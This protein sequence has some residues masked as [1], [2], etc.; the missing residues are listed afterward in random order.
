MLLPVLIPVLLGFTGSAGL[1]ASRVSA[2]AHV[3]NGLFDG[4]K[5]AFKPLAPQDE[6]R[7]T[8]IDRWLGIDKD[9]R[10]QTPVRTFVEPSDA[11]N[12][13]IIALAKPMG[14]K[15]VENEDGKGIVVQALVDSGSAATTAADIKPGDQLVSVDGT[16]VLGLD[17][18]TALG[19]IM[20]SADSTVKMTV[21]RGP[22]QFLYGPT[23]P[24]DEWLRANVSA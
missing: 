7:I 3:A 10:K 23:R 8:P 2:R 5:D 21:F 12:Y 9:V 22:A 17:F 6:D 14:I 19:A 11:A 1:R 16:L 15:F 13:R 18:D 24:N 4:V 20:A